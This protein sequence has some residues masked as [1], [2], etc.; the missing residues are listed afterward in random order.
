[1]DAFIVLFKA[2]AVPLLVGF[3]ILVLLRLCGM[4]IIRF[5]WFMRRKIGF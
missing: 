5:Y 2:F 4:Y 3:V 1:M